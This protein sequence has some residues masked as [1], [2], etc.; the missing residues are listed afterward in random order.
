M[1]KTESPQTKVGGGVRDAIQAKLDR[2]DGLQDN[3]LLEVFLLKTKPNFL[4][5][6]WISW[7]RPGEPDIN[8]IS[9]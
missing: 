7:K 3:D 2:V 6:I 9:G 8:S 5:F 1:G 4:N